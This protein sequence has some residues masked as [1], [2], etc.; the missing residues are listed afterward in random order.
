MVAAFLYG[1]LLG[2]V[3][4]VVYAAT[5]PRRHPIND[6]RRSLA[7]GAIGYVTIVLVPALKYPAN[8]P[9]VG[10]PDTIGARTVSYLTLLGASILLAVLARIFWTRLHERGFV[11]EVQVVAVG[12]AW[13][14]AVAL[15][16]LIWPA[17]PD[18]V[19][20]PAQLLWRFRLATLGGALALWMTVAL[21]FGWATTRFVLRRQHTEA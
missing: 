21:V 8:P 5:R 7:L 1:V 12:G 3:F 20:I 19:S 4:A 10:D 2:A 11:E 14:I 9:G 6:F 16:S 15:A 18:A 17:S 13:L